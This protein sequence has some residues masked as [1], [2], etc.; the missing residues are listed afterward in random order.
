MYEALML[1]DSICNSQW[2]ANTS[3]ILFLNKVDI[4]KEK[5]RRSPIKAYF[6][7]YTGILPTP[8]RKRFYGRLVTIMSRIIKR[9]RKRGRLL[10]QTIWETEPQYQEAHLCTLHRSNRH[11]T[12][13]SRHG[14][15]IRQHPA[16]KRP[17]TLTLGTLSPT[18]KSHPPYLLF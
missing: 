17:N 18:E 4:F 1:F 14:L 3:M 11:P 7:D 12:I 2:F 8:S 15:C 5:I 16:R 6:P 9:L 10:S 13:G